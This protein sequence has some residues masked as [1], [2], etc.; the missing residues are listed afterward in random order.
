MIFNAVI[1]DLDNTLYNYSLCHE[2]ALDEVA[3]YLGYDLSDFADIYSKITKRFKIET[4][5][6]ASSHNRF[7]YFKWIKEHLKANFSVENI[8][9]IYWKTYFSNMVLYEGVVDVLDYLKRSGIKIVMLTDFLTEY[10]YKKLNELGISE[11]FNLIV[12]S[13]E[14]GIEK[15]SIKGFQYILSKIEEPANKVIMVGDDE[16]KDILGAKNIGIYGFL[17]KNPTKYKFKLEVSNNRGMFSSYY[18]LLYFFTNIEKDVNDL[19]LLCRYFGERFDLTQAAGGNIS[20]KSDHIILIKSSGVELGNVTDKSGYSI[21]KNKDNP[22]GHFLGTTG[23][24]EDVKDGDYKDLNYYNM[25]NSNRASMETYMHSFLDTYVIHIHPIQVNKILIRKDAREIIGK[26]FPDSIFI[27]Y[28]KPGIDL[29]KVI[30]DSVKN[31]KG[32]KLIFLGNHGMIFSTHQYLNII[33]T[34]EYIM[35]KCEEYLGINYSKYKIVNAISLI[36]DNKC[37]TYLAEELNKYVGNIDF[38]T[39]FPDKVIYCG[40][41]HLS[42]DVVMSDEDFDK[43]NFNEYNVFSFQGNMYVTGKNITKCREIES[44][45]KAHFMIMEN[46]DNINYLSIDDE[47]QLLNMEA[48]K[49][50][51][52]I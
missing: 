28:I 9:D 13:E 45:L 19:E 43:I 24:S 16:M 29:S 35:D 39:V 30:Y 25:F 27:D 32:D 6:T 40:L 48:E 2:M 20:I 7:I 37:V 26:L 34:I 38:G 41:K 49:Y 8:N 50:R 3:T 52:S 23:L 47:Y 5:N 15:P 11:Y 42:M 1:F 46:N 4:G 31:I 21:V 51:Q 33:N 36:K 10:Q 22:N 44:V 12:S 17:F 18:D 14:I